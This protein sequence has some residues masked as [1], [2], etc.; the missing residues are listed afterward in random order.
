L[1]KSI[2]DNPLKAT[3]IDMEIRM[4]E[5]AKERQKIEIQT[6]IQ[7]QI[8]RQQR[9]KMLE[10]KGSPSKYKISESKVGGKSLFFNNL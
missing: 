7:H 5:K 9:K 3:T 1:N 10:D 2:Y 4:L 6:L 8:N